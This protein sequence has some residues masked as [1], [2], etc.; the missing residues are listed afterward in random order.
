MAKTNYLPRADKD[1]VVWLNNF[2]VKFATSAV[3][4]G[5]TAADVTSVSNDTAMFAYL[6]NQVEIYTSAKEQRVDYKNLDSSWNRF[7]LKSVKNGYKNH[8]KSR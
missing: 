7:T 6:V 2:S 3:G 4:L 1:R 5:F 8:S